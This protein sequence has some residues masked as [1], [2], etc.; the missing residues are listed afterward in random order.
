MDEFIQALTFDDVLLSPQYSDIL[1]TEVNTSSRLTKNIVLNIPLLSSAMDTVT[2][3]ELAIALARE[4]GIGIIHKNLKIEE[5]ASQV[6]K[7]KRSDSAIIS[8]PVTMRPEDKIREALRIMK[9]EGISGIPIV[10]NE[11]LMGII[12]NRDLRFIK[13]LDDPIE[14]HMTP[15]NKLVVARENTQMEEAINLMQEHKVEKL[16]IV[17]GNFKLKG[18]ITIKDVNKITEFPFASKDEKGHL[19][20]GASVGVTPQEKERAAALVKAGVDVIVVDTAHG[21]SKNVA[22]MVQYIKKNFKV[23]VIGGNIATTE[24][25]EFLIKAGVDAVKVGIGPGSICTTRIV[26]GIGVPQITAIRLALK[27]AQKYNIPV[28]A[29]GGV[30]Y[31]GDIAKAIAAG[32][33]TVMLGSLFAG[34]EESPGELVIYGGKTYKAYRGMGSLSAMEKGSKD[35]YGQM[36]I[37]EN[38]KLVPEGIEGVVPYKGKLSPFVYQ[39]VGGL[40]AAM[41]YTGAATI[42]DFQKKAR[43]VQITDASL[44]E[45][46]PHDVLITKEAPNYRTDM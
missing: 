27:A 2:E 28:I 33:S 11:T 44:K 41:G 19:R 25:A 18:L 6:A 4:G 45:S 10:K 8:D 42:D 3:A 24:G 23:D 20:V 14:K 40:K 29:D 7:V 37:K 12:T 13:Q 1:P 17:D 32:A 16:L 36:D 22:S 9:E 39:M 43:F 46:H 34:T 35:R 21:H 5:Q 31:S 30:K 15:K 38:N 26:T